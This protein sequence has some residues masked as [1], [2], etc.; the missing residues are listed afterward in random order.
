[1]FVASWRG[2]RRYSWRR[3]TWYCRA[4]A[5]NKPRRWT[6]DELLLVLHLY[7]RIPFG[8]QHSRNPQVI[9]LASVVGRT[10]SSVAMKLNNITSLDPQEA[11]RGVKG[12]DGASVLDALVWDEFVNNRA[13]VAPESEA[14]WRIRVEQRAPDERNA[15]GTVRDERPTET[16]GERRLRLGQE[17]FRRVVL[18][19][20]NNRCAI[21]GIDHPALVN[22]SHIAPWATDPR[23]RLDASN[24]IALDRLHDAAFDQRLITFDE[25][26]R[27][28]VGRRLRDAFPKGDA[29]R[30]FACEGRRLEEP[31]RYG[32]SE[33]LLA[34]HRREF[35]QANA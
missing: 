30:F 29:T 7:A 19:N 21:T 31:V 32:L 34:G 24:G 11:A 12:L 35:A 15:R 20:F 28:V 16:T 25:Q 1:M 26:H 33:V 4:V 17:F 10:P 18:A 5:A 23:H 13:V 2:P 27:L 9:E 3:S 6:R 8:Q 14:L 22:A